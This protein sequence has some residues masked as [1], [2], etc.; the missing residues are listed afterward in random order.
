LQRLHHQVQ[1]EQEVEK[2]KDEQF[3]K[4]RLMVPKNKEWRA[5]P[6]GHLAGPV[7]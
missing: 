5:K 6:V 1:Q 7:N 3:N 2:L 4:Y